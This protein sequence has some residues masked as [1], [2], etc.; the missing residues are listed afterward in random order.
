MNNF[1]GFEFFG[2]FENATGLYP[3]SKEFR[4]NQI[5]AE[6]LYRFGKEENFYV[7]GRYN[8]VKGNTDTKNPA[9]VDQTVS[10]IQFGAGWY[11]LKSTLV[12]LEY[13]KQD[14]SEF[15][16]TFGADAGFKGLMF[17]ATVSF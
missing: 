8:V 10:R 5:A 13:V 3:T 12:K 16:Q 2:T 7:G 17:E 11:M 14:Y 6:A 4:F 15:I 9:S 1:Y